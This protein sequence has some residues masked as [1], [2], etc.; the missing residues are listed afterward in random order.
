MYNKSIA[1][2]LPLTVRQIVLQ[3]L[4]FTMG[5]V[6]M[7]PLSN[8]CSIE[9]LYLREDAITV[10][11]MMQ[12]TMMRTE[13]MTILIVVAQTEVCIRLLK[14]SSSLP[15]V[16]VDSLS[17]YIYSIPYCSDY[18]NGY[19]LSKKVLTLQETRILSFAIIRYTKGQTYCCLRTSTIRIIF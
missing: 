10:M 15:L 6:W 17:V 5:T 11:V 1:S 14:R 9:I 7:D 16:L 18:C 19:S 2:H 4:K 13:T 3:A 8:R 12:S